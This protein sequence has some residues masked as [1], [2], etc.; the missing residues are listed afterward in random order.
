MKKIF[1][2]ITTVC[3]LSSAVAQN[4]PNLNRAIRPVSGPPPSI[5]LGDIK[6]F[7]LP[8]GLKVFVVENNKVPTVAYSVVLNIHPALEGDAAGL[9]AVTSDLITSGT[10][11]RSKDQ[12]DNDIDFIGAQLSASTTGLYASALSKQNKKL[13]E[14]LADVLLN[15]DFKQEE[16]DKIK[17][18]TLSALAQEKDDPDAIAS[19][20]QGVLNFGKNH[21]YGELT[22]ESTLNNITLEKCNTYFQTYFRPNVAYLAIVG[23]VK[24]SE[25]KPMIE[26]TFAGW[27]KAEVPS[28]IPPLPPIPT[29]TTVAFVNK[30]GAVQ[31]VINVTYPVELKPNSDDLIKTKVLNN[32]L[33]G[34]FSSRLFMNLREKNGYTYGSY[35]S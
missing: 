4:T 7:E 21:P 13:L 18:Q 32:I 2:A 11:T 19:N 23:D 27:Q 3:I 33:G 17:K 14:I 34:G 24:F 6:S 35:S 8:N 29:K 31:S 20:V 10:K 1:L 26:K 25:I 9:A 16:L 12:L 28:L 30:P 15:P 5:K 22:T